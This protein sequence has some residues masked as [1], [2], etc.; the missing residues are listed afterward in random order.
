MLARNVTGVRIDYKSINYVLLDDEPEVKGSSLLIA[1][2]I[3]N[4]NNNSMLKLVNT[5]LFP[6]RNGIVS[7][8]LLLFSPAV[9]LRV[10]HLNKKSYSGAL[11]GLGYDKKRTRALYVEND[12]EDVFDVEFD[13]NDIDQVNFS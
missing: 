13:S 8:C 1:H 5:C 11:C 2:K 12:I 3:E 4:C 6:K 7:L 9:E 10:N